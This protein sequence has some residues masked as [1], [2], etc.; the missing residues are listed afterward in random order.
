[1]DN[2]NNNCSTSKYIID[3]AFNLDYD[4]LV[5]IKEIPNYKCFINENI[6]KKIYQ[7][8]FEILRT[9]NIIYNI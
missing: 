3:D 6:Q 8:D 2:H 4:V 9:K 5:K 7:K 1:L